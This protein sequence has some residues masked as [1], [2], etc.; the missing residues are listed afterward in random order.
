VLAITRFRV[1][2]P[3]D[4][5]FLEQARTALAALGARPGF[6]R[7]HLGRATD[8]PQLWLLSTEWEGV[9]AYRRALS[10]YDVK[11][12]ATEV[13]LRAVQEPGA[14]EVVASWEG[15]EQG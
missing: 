14:F 4:A 5:T 15:A 3:D 10:S 13:F 6:V 2:G 8:D 11:V 12:R 1:D 7:G 9:G